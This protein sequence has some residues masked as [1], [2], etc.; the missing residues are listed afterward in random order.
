TNNTISYSNVEAYANAT[1]GV[2]LF[3]TSTIAG[4][5]SNNIIN[6]CSINGTV[7]SNTS[8]LC[9]YSAGTVGKENS[10]NTISNS[11]IYN[12]RDRAL[13]V[14]ATGSTA[15]TISGNS[16]YNGSVS[17]SINFAAASTLHGIRVLGGSGY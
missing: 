12:Y 14:T 3:S 11:T 5:N 13:D 1:N 7:S 4:G 16:F 8:N 6:Y 15:W 2:I 9:I 17:A 10:T